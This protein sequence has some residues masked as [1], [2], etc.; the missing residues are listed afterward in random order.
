MENFSLGSIEAFGE[1]LKKR[2]K[3]M[4]YS[5]SVLAERSGLTQP[6]VSAL[7]RGA[8]MR[9]DTALLL[10][11]TLGHEIVL[12]PRELLPATEALLAGGHEESEKALYALE[13]E[14]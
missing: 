6:Q 5:Q 12:V 14:D 10:A 7:E 13:D 3:E 1:A 2:R 4:G 11:R 9:M 8:N